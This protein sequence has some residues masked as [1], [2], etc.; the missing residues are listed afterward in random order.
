MGGL[1]GLWGYI[2]MC[3]IAGIY[4]FKNK[5]TG[6]HYIR[7]CISTMKH[8][9]PD[10]QQVWDNGKNY[11]AGFARLAIQDTSAAANQPMF[12]SCGN[13]CIT[14]NGE[15]YNAALLKE[16]LR[17]FSISFK[18]HSDTEALLYA[19]IHLG[20]KEALSLADGIFAFAFY[21]Q[22]K[23]ELILARD[24]VGVKPLYIGF[25]NEGLIYSSQYDHIMNYPPLASNGF[26]E[27]ALGSFFSLG[28]IPEDMA[29]HHN[30]KMLLHGHYYVVNEN[31]IEA[32]QYYNYPLL[33][34]QNSINNID[35]IL[36][37]S[38]SSQLISDVPLGTFMSG[39]VD[40]TLVT[41]FAKQQTDISSFTVG[42]YDKI[43]DES[44]ASSAYAKIFGVKNE[45]RFLGDNEIL[46]VVKENFKA[47]TEPFADHSSLPML[48]LSKFAKEKVTVALS[49]DGGDELFFG[50]WK[51]AKVLSTLRYY[52]TGG[53]A[54]RRIKLLQ[55]KLKRDN[56]ADISRHWNEEDFLSY[57]YHS[58]YIT[59]AFHFTPRIFKEKA[60]EAWWYKQLRQQYDDS[61]I[62][63]TGMYALRKLEVDV[64][65]QRMLL[66]VDRAGMYHSLEIRVPMLSHAMLQYSAGLRF[67]DCFK[68]SNGKM[69]L[70][71]S[72]IQKAGSKLVMQPKKGFD[73]P[74]NQFI[75]GPLKKDFEEK[76]LNMPSS[77]SYLFNKSELEKCWQLHV[78][79]KHE[80]GWLLWAVYS[81]VC[82][83]DMHKD[84]YCD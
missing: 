19:I 47:Y 67:E 3:G 16:K 50:Y 63:A 36:A 44:E 40:S 20:I 38:V 54:A 29:A 30:A 81:F 24:R 41:Y 12:S 21:D 17:P 60:A 37:Q 59:G 78:Q 33:V 10:D 66:K 69:P 84:K 51:N 32:I 55:G 45:C 42:S 39:G 2:F 49:G 31:G 28:Y 82:W 79:Q 15:I 62:T 14:Y 83:Y 7:W 46:D 6:N 35:D 4:N 11:T 65:M 80:A 56:T 23:N 77:I 48:L 64:H 75:R 22:Q 76:I 18:T 61:D 43:F 57:C 9:G 25:N 70:K 8:R 71:E 52:A 5:G 74:I 34:E 26:N 1:N 68:N 73:I 27:A 72:L 58:L 53:L 13:Y